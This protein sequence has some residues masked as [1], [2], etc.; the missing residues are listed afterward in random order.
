MNAHFS[1]L[2]IIAQYLVLFDAIENFMDLKPINHLVID[3]DYFYLQKYKH[4]F[5]KYTLN[6]RF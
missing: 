2:E 5:D 6:V 4:F 1:I 3:L